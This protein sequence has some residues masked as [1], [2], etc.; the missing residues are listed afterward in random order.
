[1]AIASG[2]RSEPVEDTTSGLRITTARISRIPEA[3]RRKSTVDVAASTVPVTPKASP[4]KEGSA[5][6]TMLPTSSR[7][8][9]VAVQVGDLQDVELA[10]DQL[11][12]PGK[13]AGP[14]SPD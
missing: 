13:D 8:A 1:M 4:S 14:T 3:Q 11:D 12:R 2:L 9:T 10:S 5:L 6:R 7:N